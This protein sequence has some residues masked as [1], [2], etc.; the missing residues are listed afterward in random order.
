LFLLGVGGG[1]VLN[2][3]YERLEKFLILEENN[4]LEYAKNNPKNYDSMFRID[5]EEFKSSIEFKEYLQ[6]QEILVTNLTDICIGW[7][8]AV[9][10]EISIKLFRLIFYKIKNR[11]YIL[12]K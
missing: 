1:G 9:L 4:Q 7:F 6:Q 5:L 8:F 12:P 11:K 2:D 3:G 10:T